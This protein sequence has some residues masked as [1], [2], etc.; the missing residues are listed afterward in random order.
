[1]NSDL[2]FYMWLISF[3]LFVIFLQSGGACSYGG[4]EVLSSSP[5]GGPSLNSLH[6]QNFTVGKKNF[7]TVSHLIEKIVLELI[8]FG[9]LCC[10]D[11]GLKMVVKARR[12][13]GRESVVLQ[14]LWCFR[15]CCV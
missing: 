8:D 15:G 4:W 1:M 3:F 12:F 7:T 11:H 5:V 14:I 9:C 2:S 6:F 13:I 10:L